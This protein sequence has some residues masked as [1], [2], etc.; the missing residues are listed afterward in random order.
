VPKVAELGL[1][2]IFSGS[3]LMCG[4][5]FAKN[6]GIKYVYM[7]DRPLGLSYLLMRI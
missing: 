1:V 5:T 6:I 2:V 3:D 4:I 7:R